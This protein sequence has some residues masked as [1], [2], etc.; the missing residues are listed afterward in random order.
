MEQLKAFYDYA[1]KCFRINVASLDGAVLAN[2]LQTYLAQNDAE[3]I[4]TLDADSVRALALFIPRVPAMAD[5]LA[6][7]CDELAREDRILALSFLEKL[8][9]KYEWIRRHSTK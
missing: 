7:A 6:R 2:L 5:A 8:D 4:C 1:D 9:E 3:F